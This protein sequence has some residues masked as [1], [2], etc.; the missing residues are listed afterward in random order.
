MLTNP[1]STGFTDW[2]LRTSARTFSWYLLRMPASSSCDF[3]WTWIPMTLRWGNVPSSR[4][5]IRSGSSTPNFDGVGA[6]PLNE[7]SGLTRTPIP[8]TLPSLSARASMSSISPMLSAMIIDLSMVSSMSC[9]DLPGTEYMMSSLPTPMEWAIRTSPEL[10]ASAPNPFLN[11]HSET[12]LLE[13]HFM[14]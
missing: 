4:I 10:A 8:M 11:M 14:E 12:C 9:T 7:K 5:L 1:I 2:I 6:P 13:L 3:R